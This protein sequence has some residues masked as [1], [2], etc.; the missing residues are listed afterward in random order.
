MLYHFSL[1]S[2]CPIQYVRN[3]LCPL[4]LHSSFPHLS[5]SYCT[6]SA[7]LKSAFLKPALSRTIYTVSISWLS[8]ETKGHQ[9]SGSINIYYGSGSTDSCIDPN[10]GSVSKQEAQSITDPAGSGS[11]LAIFVAIEKICCQI[12]SKSS[13]IFAF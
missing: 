8:G 2:T 6:C 1:F 12:G 3:A 13:N 11:Y 7:H 5:T 9:S 10:Y 4:F